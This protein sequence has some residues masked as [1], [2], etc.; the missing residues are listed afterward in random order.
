MVRKTLAAGLLAGVVVAAGMG[1]AWVHFVDL[2]TILLTYGVG[3]MLWMLAGGAG[4]RAIWTALRSEGATELELAKAELS[5]AAARRAVWTAGGIGTLIGLVQL[6][7][8]I[9]DPAAVGPAL[10]STGFALMYAAVADLLVLTP[11]H[12][13]LRRKQLGAGVDLPVAPTHEGTRPRRT[14]RPQASSG[15]PR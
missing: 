4:L 13:S 14:A 6:L 5:V 7:Q 2:S 12:A 1:G 15:G 10:A 8:A 9:D 3:Y 11:V